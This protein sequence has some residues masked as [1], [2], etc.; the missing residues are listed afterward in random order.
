MNFDEAYKYTEGIAGLYTQL[1]CE[2]L[3]EYAAPCKGLMVELGSF[4]GKSASLLLQA[5]T[6]TDATVILVDCWKWMKGHAVNTMQVLDDF[7]EVKKAIL[8]MYTKDAAKWVPFH[9]NL[10]H[11]DANHE[12]IG[13]EEDC[14]MWLPK[15]VSG[16]VVCFHDYGLGYEGLMHQVDKYTRG[17]KDLGIWDTLAIRRKP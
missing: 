12:E 4:N 1:N 5:A 17:W 6:T 7:P 13:V 3:W 9:I 11:I 10:L 14:R 2:K 15:V 16:G 8:Y